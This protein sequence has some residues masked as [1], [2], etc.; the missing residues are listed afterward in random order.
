MAKRFPTGQALHDKTHA[1]HAKRLR[2]IDITKY[3]K[4]LPKR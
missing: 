3:L 4:V 2:M 1:L